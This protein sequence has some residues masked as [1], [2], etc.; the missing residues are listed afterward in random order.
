MKLS[1]RAFIGLATAGV[2]CLFNVKP[3]R[4][5]PPPTHPKATEDPAHP[6]LYLIGQ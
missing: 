1:R 2:A 6:G 4:D 3:N 5:T